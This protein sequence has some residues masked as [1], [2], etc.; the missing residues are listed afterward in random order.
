MKIKNES[1]VWNA[2]KFPILKSKSFIEKT[3]SWTCEK[4][5]ETM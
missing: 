3:D 4:F 1:D 5:F 2:Y